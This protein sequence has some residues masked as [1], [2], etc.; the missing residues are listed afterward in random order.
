MYSNLKVIK[1]GN[2]VKL[3]SLNLK[4]SN[5]IIAEDIKSNVNNHKLE[6]NL[7]RAKNH[8]SSIVLA[9]D[10][11]YFFTLTFNPSYDRYELYSLLNKFRNMLKVM[12]R[13]AGDSIKYLIVPEKH[14]DGAWHF[15][16][17]FTEAIDKFVFYNE[18][19][20][21]SIHGLK[22][23]GFVN[24]SQ[25]KD[26]LRCS[27]YVTKYVTKNLGDG[28]KMYR[29]SYFCSTGLSRG[30]LVYDKVYD[31]EFFNNTFFDYKNDYCRIKTVS[32]QEYYNLKIFIDK[33]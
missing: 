30:E 12:S 14:K 18:Y 4:T 31:N 21:L 13:T 19:G 33:L 32:L 23:L 1:L 16:G 5:R 25:I 22:N 10:F 17:F 8:I 3:V 26:K 15:H 7:I 11:K 29:N 28:I 24:I 2:Y 9:N 20:F 27:S 6:N